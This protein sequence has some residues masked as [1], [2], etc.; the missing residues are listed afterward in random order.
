[1]TEL[2]SLYMTDHAIKLAFILQYAANISLRYRCNNSNA[3]P[4]YVIILLHE[5]DGTAL[6][7]SRN[8]EFK[9]LHLRGEL[10]NL[11]ER[12]KNYT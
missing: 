9:P 11:S 4:L 12:T 3:K 1:M 2:G 7:T 5:F 6:L 8:K 10:E